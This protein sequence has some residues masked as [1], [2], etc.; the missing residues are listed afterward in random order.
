MLLVV[1]SHARAAEGGG[2]EN[3]NHGLRRQLD[4]GGDEENPGDVEEG[5]GTGDRGND[6]GGSKPNDPA[7]NEEE[8]GGGG[9]DDGQKVSTEASGDNSNN[10]D[11]DKPGEG[12]DSENDG[13]GK[14]STPSPHVDNNT[15][16]SKENPLVITDVDEG[17]GGTI[18]SL[19]FLLAIGGFA[20]Y[21]K[22]KVMKIV[23]AEMSP[24]AKTAK[25][26]EV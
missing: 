7:E 21:C 8:N 5:D 17:T 18:I 26:L 16:T 12:E 24:S 3:Y 22:D 4:D 10:G 23:G 20:F 1:I 25:Y 11:D 6:D 13:G 9:D 19:V 14:P 15:D 2:E